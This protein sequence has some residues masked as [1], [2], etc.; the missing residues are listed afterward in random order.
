MVAVLV[1]VAV[2]AIADNSR[3]GT[4]K[5]IDDAE[6]IEVW[7][8]EL[9]GVELPGFRGEVVI[10]APPE[11]IVEVLKQTEH[12]TEW[13]KN[14]VA[15]EVVKSFDPDHTIVYNRTHVPWPVW[16]RDVILESQF[17]YEG[18][19]TTLAFHEADP[20]LRPLP[21]K[22]VRM[23]RLAGSYLLTKLGPAQTRVRY[24]IEVDVGGSLPAWLAKRVAKEMPY[25]TLARLRARVTG[26]K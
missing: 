23:P 1:A 5:Q 12:H 20:T 4:W 19:T 13:M 24:T 11:K 15:S 26:K 22:V 3:E 8:L 17:T 6:G 21:E 25:E 9:P 14:C 18:A 7:R 16:D 2:P 10:D